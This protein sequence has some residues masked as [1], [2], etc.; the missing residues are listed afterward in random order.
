MPAFWGYPPWPHDHPYYCFILD[1]KSEQ[2]KVKVTNLKNLPKFKIFYLLY[3]RHNLLKFLDK[4]CKWNGSGKYC[5]RY[6]ADT[7]LSTDGQTDKVKSVYPPFNFVEAGGIMS[8][9]HT[10]FLYG[11]S[12]MSHAGHTNVMKRCIRTNNTLMVRL[13]GAMATSVTTP[14]NIVNSTW[15]TGLSAWRK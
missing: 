14:Q 10:H 1:P 9:M 13:S 8:L 15:L 5:W 2:D 3:T 4:M 11:C 7:I 12:P 6:I